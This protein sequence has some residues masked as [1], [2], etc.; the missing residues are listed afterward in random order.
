MNWGTKL[1]FAMALF[2]AFILTL[3][4]RMIFS[5][6][7]ALIESNYYENGLNY[8]QKY[9]A[10]Q[11]AITDSVLPSIKLDNSG[12]H[13]CFVA[14][15]HCKLSFKRA[16][17]SKQDTVF[18]RFTDQD[19]CI[20]TSAGQIGKGPWFFSIEYKLNNKTYLFEKDILMP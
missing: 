14:P 4:I 11:S 12:M 9:N 3:S 19:H 5:N 16:S 2:M 8:S 10:K 17:D 20:R 7:D 15:A 6:D 13:I 1:I 18:H